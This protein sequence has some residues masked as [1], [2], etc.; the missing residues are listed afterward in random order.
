ME[1]AHAEAI[2]TVAVGSDEGLD[3]RIGE[4]L[5]LRIFLVIKR[6]YVRYDIGA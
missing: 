5:H 6:I 4:G 3:L 2:I 1:I